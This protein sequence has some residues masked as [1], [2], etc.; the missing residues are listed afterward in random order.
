M[1][2]KKLS[3]SLTKEYV[4]QSILPQRSRDTSGKKENVQKICTTSEKFENIL[5]L[6]KEE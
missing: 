5:Y 2:N 3:F 4:K 1:A 6:Q